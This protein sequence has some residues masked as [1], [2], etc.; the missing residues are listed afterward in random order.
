MK[1]SKKTIISS[2][3]F[4]LKVIG[5]FVLIQITRFV[6]GNLDAVYS[7]LSLLLIASLLFIGAFLIAMTKDRRQKREQSRSQ[8]GL[9]V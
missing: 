3:W 7:S 8:T 6:I 9:Q 2:F 1:I 4:A 5:V